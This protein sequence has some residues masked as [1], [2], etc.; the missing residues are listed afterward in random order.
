M[1]LVQSQLPRLREPNLNYSR[2]YKDE[3]AYT[4]QNQEY[5]GGVYV[6]LVSWIGFSPKYAEFY[7]KKTGNIV[8]LQIFKK[9]V[10][11][12]MVGARIVIT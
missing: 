1:E 7:A 10:A 5:E 9:R 11:K 2:V 6:D 12:V 8:Y 4:F 3:C